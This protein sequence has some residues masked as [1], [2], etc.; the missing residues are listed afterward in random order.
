MA[1]AAPATGHR[2]SRD[3]ATGV[4]KNDWH[5]LSD[6][7]THALTCTWSATFVR[8]SVTLASLLLLVSAREE[9]SVPDPRATVNFTVSP[10][11][12]VALSIT[13]AVS[14]RVTLPP[15]TTQEYGEVSPIA[16][17]VSV[18]TTVVETDFDRG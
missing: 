1:C 4:T 13:R 18:P 15:A 3:A 14:G 8:V 12:R 16:R 10:L 17:D 7:A 5:G 11:R 2:F 6:G 9:L